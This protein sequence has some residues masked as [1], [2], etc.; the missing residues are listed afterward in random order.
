MERMEGGGLQLGCKSQRTSFR[1]PQRLQDLN[2]KLDPTGKRGRQVQLL[3]DLH[4]E[5]FLPW[6]CDPNKF[7]SLSGPRF[8]WL[9]TSC[10]ALRWVC[11][12][13]SQV[14]GQQPL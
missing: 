4:S 1:P 12:G 2:C 10:V 8:S 11:T 6:P 7:P 5:S 9:K 3:G 13:N 14:R